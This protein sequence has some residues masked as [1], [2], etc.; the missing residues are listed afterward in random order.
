MLKRIKDKFVEMTSYVGEDEE[1]NEC[2]I[3][4]TVE[5]FVVEFFIMLIV[6]VGVVIYCY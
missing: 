2:R 1:G 6:F 5:E 4:W 3:P